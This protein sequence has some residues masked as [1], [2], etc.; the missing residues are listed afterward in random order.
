MRVFLQKALCELSVQEVARIVIYYVTMNYLLLKLSAEEP[1]I[2]SSVDLILAQVAC[3]SKAHILLCSIETYKTGI[4]ERHPRWPAVSQQLILPDGNHWQV[5][6]LIHHI[7]H[8]DP[9]EPRQYCST[10]SPRSMVRSSLSVAAPSCICS[11]IRIVGF[12]S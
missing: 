9:L 10:T 8:N 4:F 6:E 5:Q 12:T 2:V 1:K 3:S 11:P 7:K